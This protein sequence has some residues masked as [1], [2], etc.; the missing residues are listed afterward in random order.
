MAG[1]LSED[2]FIELV[3]GGLSVDIVGDDPGPVVI[4]VVAGG[5]LGESLEFACRVSSIVLT[6]PTAAF[7]FV[8]EV[9]LEAIVKSAFRTG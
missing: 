5:P 7:P 9:S 1:V 4:A 2:A 6:V 3:E 8:L